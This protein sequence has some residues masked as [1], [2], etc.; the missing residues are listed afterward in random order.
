[1]NEEWKSMIAQKGGSVKDRL[2]AK[3]I[4]DDTDTIRNQ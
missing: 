3:L 4:L 2:R 1:M